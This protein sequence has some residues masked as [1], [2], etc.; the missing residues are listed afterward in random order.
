MD[1]P[2]QK[3]A[4]TYREDSRCQTY[5]RTAAGGHCRCQPTGDGTSRYPKSGTMMK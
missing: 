1:Y 2:G 4:K 3:K 5:Q